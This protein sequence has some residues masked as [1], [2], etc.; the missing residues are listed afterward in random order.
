MLYTLDELWKI[1]S[2]I[3]D[4]LKVRQVCLNTVFYVPVYKKRHF[5]ILKK[6]NGPNVL[7]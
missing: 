6:E 4:V 5:K 2:L 1:C 3:Q 7:M